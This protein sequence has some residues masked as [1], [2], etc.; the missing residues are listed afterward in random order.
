M[1]DTKK[2]SW[3]PRMNCLLY[4]LGRINKIPSTNSKDDIHNICIREPLI[5][6]Q[7]LENNKEKL[8]KTSRL[9]Q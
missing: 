9:Q 2:A 4:P 6:P 7:V 3:L 5:L 8:N 1:E